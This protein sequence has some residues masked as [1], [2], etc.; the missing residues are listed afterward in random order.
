MLNNEELA[1]FKQ[2]L[3]KMKQQ[4]E[5]N[6]DNTSLEMNGLSDTCPRDEGDHASVERGN[7]VG[8]TIITKQSEKLKAIERSLKRIN[9]GTYG[10]CEACGV[11]I[12]TERLK[13]KIFADYCIACR[14]IIEKETARS[15]NTP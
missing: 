9:N 15:Q 1:Y 10:I 5:R 4:I 14:E 2:E 7:S 11:P 12:R 3:E 8:N 6:L 13:V